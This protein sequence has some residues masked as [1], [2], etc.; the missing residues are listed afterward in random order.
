[1]ALY[2][3]S[4]DTRSFAQKLLA[5][6]PHLEITHCQ[7]PAEILE[8][9]DIVVTATFATEAVLPNDKELLKGKCFIAVGSYKPEM[10]ELPDG[11]FELTDTIYVDLLHALDESGDLIT[12][13]KTGL[14]SRNRIQ[15]LH[16]LLNNKPVIHPGETTVFK[17]V[18][19][20]LMDIYA[21]GYLFQKAEGAKAGVF[22]DM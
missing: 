16:T 5:R 18:G 9:S 13:M 10:R 21:A 19:M 4:T 20:A 22:V 15:L 6:Y 17:T 7:S 1:V 8:Q 3:R 11:V 14:L 12:P 2:N